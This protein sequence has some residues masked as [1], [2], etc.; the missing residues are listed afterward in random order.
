MSELKIVMSGDEAKL[1][2]SL[3]RVVTQSD[4]IAE[5]AGRNQQASKQAEDASIKMAKEQAQAAR[6]GGR[7]IDELAKKNET[8][9]E[10]YDRQ[11]AAIEE[12]GRQGIKSPKEVAEAVKQLET[13]REAEEKTALEAE[14]KK[15]RAAIESTDAYKQ[16]QSQIGEGVKATQ[17]LIESTKTLDQKNK[18]LKTSIKAAFDAGKISAKEYD[19]AI[20]K[21]DADHIKQSLQEAE[22]KLDDSMGQG[23]LEKIGAFGAKFISAA[24]SVKVISDALQQVKKEREEALG[25]GSTLEDARR[26]L[27]GLSTDFTQLEKQ[28]DTI[29][30]TTGMDRANAR[31]L[32]FTGTSQS[33]PFQDQMLAAQVGSFA[34]SNV[35][36]TFMADMKDQFKRDNLT[37]EQAL[38]TALTAADV[39]KFDPTAML[40]Q[41]QK[42]A[43]GAAVA[44]F[45]SADTGAIVGVLAAELGQETGSRVAALFNKMAS[46]ADKRFQGRDAVESLQML[47]RMPEEER[48]EFIGGNQQIMGAIAIAMRNMNAIEQTRE[49]ILFQQR[50]AGT[51]Q[52]FTQQKLTST[53]D[54][55]TLEGRRASL[56]RNRNRSMRAR[57]MTLET[58]QLKAL[59][60]QIDDINSEVEMMQER[61]KMDVFS[62]TTNRIVESVGGLVHRTVREFGGVEANSTGPR[63]EVVE[64]L[65]NQSTEY[66]R[67]QLEATREQTGV[68]V[69]VGRKLD[70]IPAVTGL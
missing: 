18:E 13:A 44:D 31:D 24:A 10:K 56:E 63:N 17:R 7:L 57:E 29:A 5:S 6:Q 64:N 46:D 54:E 52:S 34:D 12:A 27:R 50:A 21:V 35:A 22:D 33:V 26:K 25:I 23:A 9:N 3:Q 62:A 51:D 67:Q 2:E 69:E 8:L 4:K 59:E 49:Q 41:L 37:G 47:E 43:I 45:S 32:V 61:M 65:L 42:A 11:K 53:F 55:S 38:N 68:T 58:Q 48:N 20:K 14:Q 36:M 66:Q 28:A 70:Q 1:W 39:S 15:K 40:P 16:Q 19:E 30:L 60:F